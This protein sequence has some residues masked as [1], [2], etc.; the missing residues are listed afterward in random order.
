MSKKGNKVTREHKRMQSYKRGLFCLLP[1]FLYTNP[2][3][4]SGTLYLP[5]VVL[6]PTEVGLTSQS[7][8]VASDEGGGG[9]FLEQRVKPVRG[10]VRGISAA[11]PGNRSQ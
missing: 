11:A 2:P 8:L 10:P 7:K 6:Q 1:G 5:R 3:G 9:K 4:V